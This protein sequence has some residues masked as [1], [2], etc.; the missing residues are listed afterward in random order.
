MNTAKS[1]IFT[2]KNGSLKDKFATAISTFFG[3]GLFP[4]APGTVGSVLAVI[5]WRGLYQ[6]GK[7][8]PEVFLLMIIIAGIWA[9]DIYC[10][11]VNKDD[12]QEVVIDEIGGMF[13][14]L[15]LIQPTFS[16]MIMGFLLFRLFDILKP[17]PVRTIERIGK[18]GFGIVGDDLM[19]G[20]YANISLRVIHFLK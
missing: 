9:S 10:S 4:W 13:L 8:V 7:W 14:S 11:I 12:P 2:F 16:N 3:A 6:T 20:L 17:F 18:G 19:A 1:V 5:F 15:F